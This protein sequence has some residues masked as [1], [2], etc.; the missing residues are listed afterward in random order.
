VYSKDVFKVVYA[1]LADRKCIKQVCETT[2]DQLYTRSHAL[3][4]VVEDVRVG[5]DAKK[6]NAAHARVATLG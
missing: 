5:L 6:T 1:K 4:A 2:L 3:K